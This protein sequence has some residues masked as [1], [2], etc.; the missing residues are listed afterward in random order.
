MQLFEKIESP[1][2]E[3]LCELVRNSEKPAVFK[4]ATVYTNRRNEGSL[5]SHN[6]MSLIKEGIEIIS[7]VLSN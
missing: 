3:E 6:T 5:G 7:T 2:F 4:C 1:V